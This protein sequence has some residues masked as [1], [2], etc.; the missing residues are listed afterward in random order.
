MGHQAKQKHEKKF[1]VL[2]KKVLS[3]GLNRTVEVR[4]NSSAEQFGQTKRSVDH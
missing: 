2:Q 3:F 1:F 4:P